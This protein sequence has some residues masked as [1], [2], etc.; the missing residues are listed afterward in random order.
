MANI[1][2]KSY[3]E[4][5]GDMVRKIIADT[6]VNDI[7]KGSVLL[8]LLEAAAANDFE[9][10]VAILNVLELLNIDA[11][12]NSDLD[13]HGS[14]LGLTRN[15]ATK[16]SGFIIVGDS[17][18]TKR[19]TS[20][21]P[22]KPAPI[23]G[24]SV[25][26][27]NDASTWNQTGNLYL[28]R[29]TSNFEGP[30]AY[31]SI[32]NNGTF[33]TINLAS[34]LEK[35]H[36]LSE[37]VIDGQGTTDRQVL[38]GTVVKIPAN[39]INP[40][41][42]YS[43]LRDAVI[44]AGEDVSDKIPVVAIKAGSLGNA[45]INSITLFNTLPFAG[46]T[47][48]N[49]NAFTNGIDTE[50]D[51]KFRDRIKAY[52]S[53]LARGTKRSI[54]SAIDGV[55]DE[56][57][58]KQVAS[59]VITEPAKI[60]DTSI[61]YIDDGQGFE[62]SFAG[63]SV[64]LLIA[65]A[66][67]KEEFI[68]LANYPLPRPQVLNTAESPYLFTNG[69]ELKVLIDG[70]EESVIF[71][72]SDFKSTSSATISEVVV[73]INNK[74]ETF[75]CRLSNNSTRLLLYPL[76]ERAETI[77]VVSSGG[78]LDANVQLKF[79][80][81]EFS[82]I[83]LYKNSAR[84][85]EIE[86]SASL[87]STPFSTWGITGIGNLILS[88]DETPDQDRSFSVADFG[89]TNF[90]ALTLSDWV[91]AFN[92]KYAGLTATETTT[93]RLILTS[94]KSGS[95]SILEIV[96]GSYL[97]QMFGGQDIKAIGQDSDFALNRQNGNLQIKNKI[98]TGD[99]ITAGSSDTKGAI[100]SS[101]ASGGTYNV[102][103]DANNRPAEIVIVTDATRVLPRSLNLAVGATITISDEGSNIMR[104]MASTASAFKN[105]QP[106][107][108][109]Y[110]TNRGHVAGTGAEAWIDIA[111][112]GL[113]KIEAKGE[114]L[115]D[116]VD[117]YIEVKNV[118]MVAGG[119]YT[120]ADGLDIQIFASDKYPQLWRGAD[121]INPAASAIEDVVLSINENIKGVV[122][123]IFR[124]NFIKLT[125]T[126]EE[127]GSIA[128]PVSV[129]NATQLFASGGTQQSG[130]QSHIANRV[131]NKDVFT[132]FERTTPTNTNVWLDRYT[133][134]DIKGSITADKE[135]SKDGSGT[136]S[137]TLEDT[138][139]DF[140]TNITYNDSIHITS[141]QNKKQTRDIRTIIDADNVGTRHDTPRSLLDYT[142]G[143]EYQVVKNLEFSAEDNLVAIIDDDAVSKTIDISFSRTGQINSGSQS[144]VFTP[145][146]LAF[147]ADDSDNEAG[148]DFGTLDV[149]GTLASQS[150]TNFNDYAVWFKAR[151]WYNANGAAIIIRAK[152]FGPIGDKI[153]FRIE[154]P[155][156]ANATNALSHI[157]SPDQTLVTYTYGSGAEALTNVAAADKFTLTDLGGYNFR[158]T[159]PVTATTANIN[160]GD[161]ISIGATSGFS[162]ANQGAFRINSKNDINRTIDIYNENGIATIVGNPAVQD[163][164]FTGLVAAALDGTDFVLNAPNGDTIK[165][166]Y[167]IDNSGTVEP[168]IGLATRSWEINT[169][170]TGDSD[171][172]IATKTAAVI[173]NDPAFNSATNGGGTL[174]IVTVTNTDNGPAL[175]G[176]DGPTP[177]GI[178]FS[179]VTA[180]ILDTFESLNIPS[181]LKV[182][183]IINT[184]TTDIVSKINASNI[185]EAAEHTSGNFIKATREESSTAVNELGYGHD[186]DPINGKNDL[187]SLFDS[188]SWIL[189][190]QNANP[191]FQLKTALKLNGV[192]AVYA[193][194]LAPNPD[195]ST[196]EYFKLI[197]V[198]LTNTKHHMLHR[199]L[200]QLDIVSN[201]L[202]ASD[203]KKI[204]IKSELLGSDGAIE[205]VGGRANL[206]SFKVIGDTQINTSNGVN[207]LEVQI[208]ASPNTLSPGQHVTL[209]NESG[210]ERL[211]RQ[212]DTD[213]MD[214]VKIND[215]TYEYRYNN[216]NTNFNQYVEFTIVDANSVD[217]I[218]YPTAGLVWRWSHNDSGSSLSFTDILTGSV[219]NAPLLQD[220]AGILG[221][222]TNTFLTVTDAG[223]ASTSLSFDI[224]IS[225]QPT[226]ADYIAFET[227]SGNDYAV[228]FD[229]D[230]A[231]IPPTGA[232][233][234][235]ATNK[236]QINI[237]STD[238][239]NQILS[240]L[241]SQLLVAGIAVDFNLSLSAGATL[242]DVREGNLVNAF[243]DLVGWDNTNKSFETG[244]DKIAGYPIIKV[245]SI[246]SY[247]DVVNPDGKAMSATPIGP[248]STV[249][250][251]STPI[252]EW[253]LNHSAKVEISSVT[254]ASNIATAT[255]LGSHRLN[256]G[257]VFVGTDIPAA[258]SP[259]T[260]IVLSITSSNQFTYASTNADTTV[261]PAGFLL[262]NTDNRTRYKIESL[263]YNDLYR[264]VRVSGDSPLFIS[265]GVAVDDLIT[266]GGNSF[267]TINNG[268]FR[269]IAVDEDSVIYQNSNGQEELDTFIPFNN[270]ELSATWTANSNQISG[271]A[272]T[273]TN[274][275]IGDWV[276][277]ITD[278]DTFYVQVVGFD[279]GVAATATI[280]TLA[281]NYNGITATTVGHSLDQN[282]GIGTGVYLLSENDIRVFEGDTV[283]VNDS[284]FITE[285]TNPAWFSITNSG[286]FTINALGTNVVDGKIFLR[287][288]N[289]A[290]IA[291][292]NVSQGITSAKYSITES[293]DNK[294]STIKQISHIAIDEFNPDRRIVYLS[295]GDR[296]YKWN[297]TNVTS[298]TSL[299][300]I[301]YSEDITTG[302]DGYLYYT[303]LLRKVQRIIDGFEPDTVNFPGRKAVGSL[304][305]VLPP[306]PRRVA[307]AIDVTT[308]DG[309]NLSEISDEITSVIVNYVSGLGVGEDVILSDIVVRV[310]N[311]DGVTAVTF[312]T[313]TPSSE[314]ISIS[315]DEKAFTTNSDI[316]IA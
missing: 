280:V 24:T 63:Q 78:V 61:V 272:G 21:Y 83:A 284:I 82:Y 214:V 153:K 236:I 105:A 72:D 295:P 300:K 172:V 285:N 52:S 261:T 74:S 46:A 183:P 310:K 127:G 225:G 210:V 279:T 222:Q 314:R 122:A 66:S 116:G 283:R 212:I 292:T 26:H 158:I 67:G 100:I 146:N 31:T 177:S 237:L 151:N 37:S 217:P 39:N 304:I 287:V 81:N 194:D 202:V 276:K 160:V 185:L 120:V 15:T 209:S 198:T 23:A 264:L 138:S 107:D 206:A 87:I 4:V 101:A 269:I 41:V 118:N 16:A 25:I 124:T 154:H 244:D 218:S 297:Q 192:S 80:T 103:T 50:S 65:E 180:G 47:V 134:S 228:Y 108:Y 178:L 220:A 135:P 57:D 230:G 129:G 102:S 309:I 119:P 130:T 95:S 301:G 188:K 281:N 92:V 253:R 32:V 211:N 199:A 152:E 286:T 5:L 165:F 104:V 215:E 176:S 17:T 1:N 290:G 306:L 59:A 166:W 2:I 14:N 8:T 294:F 312:I 260:G 179:L 131:A 243:G 35:D 240:K 43:V 150:N 263:G 249:L 205:V 132:I 303:G 144:G 168:D 299:G 88:V 265:S 53:T 139:I 84:M 252:I 156:I 226:Q 289:A 224:A 64:D 302:V 34:A 86:K 148:V 191:N 71:S 115:T 221:G 93:G 268:S 282:S 250:I 267:K 175:Q 73:A 169:V 18:I 121:A 259:D 69:M 157:N 275:N 245:D 296:S 233:Y 213:T 266:I 114:H 48:N 262:K 40:E 163:I 248:N 187:I 20:L 227:S 142:T 141:G 255:T 91:N 273:F 42:E 274:L 155:T 277:K 234:L 257:D 36:L 117:T 190:F 113:F 182:Y 193:M 311:I 27:V 174:P 149:W 140:Q 251:S 11:L 13:A 184:A 110:I 75:R 159:F 143:D 170:N 308:Q 271:V 56:T 256:V 96:G 106:N 10:N 109:L 133:Y 51:E 189:T 29:G 70:I 126:T 136:Y 68:Q 270:F 145:T 258:A 305:E 147:S 9:N 181:E 232:S 123:S 203:H 85:R 28:G 90:N 239:P 278:D 288:K 99:V 137:E 128:I 112:T 97:S 44:P 208:P 238:T 197:P 219:T 164:T 125:S 7:N 38:A 161:V 98:T 162:A 55:S 200:S 316:S 307:I 229:I 298:I 201:V 30:L 216:K 111:S 94:N 247:F 22:V 231:A 19:S 167:D 3:N 241:L 204:Q 242:S 246:N 77:Q 54:L 315:S 62:P 89:G 33:Y 58:G 235:A 313:P 196:G 291:Q 254:V 79:P 60:G 12:K 195:G 186:P 45:G 171:I 173:L 293:N 207:Y 76:D 6:P 223:S 49:T